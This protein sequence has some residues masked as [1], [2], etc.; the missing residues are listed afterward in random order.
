MSLIDR[1]S[2]VLIALVFVGVGTVGVFSGGS[3]ASFGVAGSLLLALSVSI[4]KQKWVV[5]SRQV[6][7]LAGLLLALAWGSCWS[8]TDF[9]LSLYS[10]FKLTTVVIPLIF[11]SC[12]PV[13]AQA[14]QSVPRIPVLVGLMI[15]S[16]GVLCLWLPYVGIK[17]GPDSGSVTKLNR[18]FSYILILFWPLAGY[19]A[20]QAA[21]TGRQKLILALFVVVILLA[22]ALTHSR[23]SQMGAAVSLVVFALAF[24]SSKVT[25]WL[26]GATSVLL[27]GWPFY[28]QYYF[29][30]LHEHMAVLPR[31]WYHR[32]EIWDYF[33]Y[34][35]QESP[36]VG[37]GLGVAHELDWLSP[38]GAL[39][40]VMSKAASHPHN[41]I[42][43][44]WVELG[45]GGLAFFAVAALG[46]L[47]GLQN[48]PQSL[49]PYALA[50]FGLVL[51]LLLFA[52]NF[53]TDSLWAAMAL[54]MLAFAA[55]GRSKLSQC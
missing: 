14:T 55:V 44:L 42:V 45:V 9:D 51:S 4:S 54:T 47:K 19:M 8:A 23:A 48:L 2:Q 52:Y 22:L 31:S 11:L 34:R 3:W 16:L 41:A 5:P 25:T 49:R 39:Y 53:W 27:L 26:L 24:F 15:V 21:K 13:I 33:S 29:T 17:D 35:I 28:A 37:H 50:C 10:A 46:L 7:M 30:R 32:I 6:A 38:H 43:Q 20:T 1:I 36:L 18:G 12:D 40:E